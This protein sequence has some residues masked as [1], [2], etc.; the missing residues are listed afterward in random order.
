MRSKASKSK[1]PATT[2]A[3]G[4]EAAVG[5]ASP[6]AASG[7]G[8]PEQPFSAAGLMPPRAPE[9]WAPQSSPRGLAKGWPAEF[10]APTSTASSLLVGSPTSV[11]MLL[12]WV[13]TMKSLPKISEACGSTGPLGADFELTPAQTLSLASVQDEGSRG[14]LEPLAP[15][16]VSSSHQSSL[17][18]R[19]GGP[20]EAQASGTSPRMITPEP[21]ACCLN[22]STTSSL[23]RQPSRSIAHSLQSL[24]N[25]AAEVAPKSNMHS[26]SCACS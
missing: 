1:M 18:L 6:Q 24:C 9:R 22:L 4:W 20:L 10:P 14:S 25:S 19:Q 26:C 17:E 13:C 11:A 7:G 21:D 2:S 15:M 3:P 23:S 12:S 8:A 16:S 5:S